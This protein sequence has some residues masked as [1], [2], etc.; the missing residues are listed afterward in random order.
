MRGVVWKRVV[1]MERTL[2]RIPQLDSADRPVSRRNAGETTESYFHLSRP[3][4]FD[5]LF[6]RKSLDLSRESAARAAEAPSHLGNPGL[7]GMR[8]R[9]KKAALTC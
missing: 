8:R 5:H 7:E 6:Q 3:P 4:G 9:I 1:G 2:A